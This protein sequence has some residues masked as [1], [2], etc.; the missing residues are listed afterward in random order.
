M[1]VD[2]PP[3]LP[4]RT[5]LDA[6]SQYPSRLQTVTSGLRTVREF[7]RFVVQRRPWEII[8]QALYFSFD[9]LLRQKIGTYDQAKPLIFLYDSF[10]LRNG[11]H[12]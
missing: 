12:E 2:E 9:L 8:V 4:V 3:A 7:G 11:M 10:L 6:T 1:T 5:S